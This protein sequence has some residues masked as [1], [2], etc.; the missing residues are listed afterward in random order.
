MQYDRTF[1]DRMRPSADMRVS[2]TVPDRP[3]AW[4]WLLLTSGAQSARL[5]RKKVAIMATRKFAL[6]LVLAASA[7]LLLAGCAGVVPGSPAPP[8]DV[9][10]TQ[11]K[12]QAVRTVTAAPPVTVTVAAKPPV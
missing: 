1:L 11:V 3:F 2:F 9:S 5:T 6:A 8:N 4:G 10:S 7:G 12:P